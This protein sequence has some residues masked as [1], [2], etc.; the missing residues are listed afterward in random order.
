MLTQKEVLEIHERAM[1]HQALIE[2]YNVFSRQCND[3]QVKN[4]LEQHKQIHYNHY[5][6][7][8]DLLQNYQGVGQQN[9]Q[10]YELTRV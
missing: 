2:K 8:M 7:L 5:K 10:N 6:I 4:L 1:G 3:P 9:L